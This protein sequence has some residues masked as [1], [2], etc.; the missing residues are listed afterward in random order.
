MSRKDGFSSILYYWWNRRY[1]KKLGKNCYF[2]G[3]I[4]VRGRYRNF[5]AGDNCT[6]G[7]HI[8]LYTSKVGKILIEDDVYIGPLVNIQAANFV[9]IGKGTRLEGEISIHDI[10]HGL[11]K[12][13][14]FLKQKNT[15]SNVSIGKGVIV[16]WGVR[17]VKGVTIGDGAVILANSVVHKDV[18]PNAIYSGVP[19]RPVNHDRR[20]NSFNET[21]PSQG[22]SH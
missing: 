4:I 17:I 3:P 16:E 5:F 11:E 13:I 7:T 9:K 1:F 6:F 10:Q 15:I 20:E 12:D 19:A 22:V 2:Q 18:P 14:P 8:I 21:H